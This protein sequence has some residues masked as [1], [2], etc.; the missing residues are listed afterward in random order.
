MLEL[1]GYNINHFEVLGNG[2]KFI[3][4]FLGADCPQGPANEEGYDGENE[5]LFLGWRRSRKQPVC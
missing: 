4:H 1:R 3:T 2:V 5:G